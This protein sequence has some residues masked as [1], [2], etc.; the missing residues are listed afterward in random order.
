VL[1]AATA[2]FAASIVG[3]P[4]DELAMGDGE[5]LVVVV[6]ACPGLGERPGAAP[7]ADELALDPASVPWPSVPAPP[8]FC[9]PP[10]TLLLA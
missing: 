10:V 8:D 9:P 1:D 2:S 7:A 3:H 4:E 5:P 6:A